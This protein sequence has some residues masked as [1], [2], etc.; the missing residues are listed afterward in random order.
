MWA[1]RGLNV[2][3]SL[4][5]W[6]VIPI[7]FVTTFVIGILVTISFGLFLL[8]ISLIWFVFFLWPLIGLSW[9]WEKV[10]FLRIPIAVI[11]IPLALIGNTYVSLMPSMGE[12]DSRASKLILT[13]SWPYSLDCWRLITTKTFPK[14]PGINNLR[15]ILAEIS[16]NNPPYMQYLEKMDE[17]EIDK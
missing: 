16:K 14:S 8:P 6:L 5:A 13:E 3:L 4:I 10:P 9:I 1:Y 2:A 15:L 7:Q 11:G 12:L 17:N